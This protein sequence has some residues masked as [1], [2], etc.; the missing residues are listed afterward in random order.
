M[1]KRSCSFSKISNAAPSLSVSTTSSGVPY[2][3]ASVRGSTPPSAGV[4]SVR[5]EP[6]FDDVPIDGLGNEIADAPAARELLANQRRPP[7]E[8]W[9]IEDAHL[10]SPVFGKLRD[11]RGEPV[12]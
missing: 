12:R 4:A 6:P 2:V 10:A 7:G 5:I 1:P 11:Q 9:K 3:S 8:R